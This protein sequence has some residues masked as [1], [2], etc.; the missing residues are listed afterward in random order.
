MTKIWAE[1]E[2]SVN[3]LQAQFADSGI[4]IEYADGKSFGVRSDRG[5]YIYCSRRLKF[6]PP[7]RLNI[8]PGRVAV[9]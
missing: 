7:C 4:A 9:F 3:N 1:N 8:D 6:A 5:L 2:I